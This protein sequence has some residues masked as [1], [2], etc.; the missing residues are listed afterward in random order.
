[1]VQ[2]FCTLCGAHIQTSAGTWAREFR[3][4]WIQGNNFDDVK[5]S[6]VAAGHWH[7]R[8]TS[9]V[10]P[11][12]PNARYDG[13]RTDDDGFPIEDVEISIINLFHPNPPPEWR[14][15]FLFH[16]ACW[17]LLNFEQKVDLGDLFRLCVSTPIGPD[18]LL[19]FGHDYGNIAS[20][21]YEGGIDVL[22]SDLKSP[23]YGSDMLRANPFEIPALRKSIN[24]AAR[25]QQDA[26][27]SILDR[28]TLSADKDVFNYFPPEILERIVMFL[29]SPDV[30]SLRLASRVFATLSLS[31]RFW[32][33]RFTEGHEFDYLPEVFATPPTSWRALYLSLH[34]WASENSGM[35]NR[36]R[37]WPFVKDLHNTL[38]QMKNVECLGNLINTTFEPEAPSSGPQRGSLITAER[39]IFEPG[40]HF[41]G[42]SRVLR[43]RFAEFPQHL[44]IM[45]MSVSF[46]DT[47]DGPF[48]SGLMFVGADGV[49][50]SLGYT[51]K[52]QMEHITLP[53]DQHVKG[54]EVALDVCGFRAIAAIT[55]DGT[56]SSW[57]GD[58]ADS[59]RRRLT[60]VEGISLIVAQF[61]ALKLVS[62]S[63]DRVTK[64][65]QEPRDR[66][67]WHPEIPAPELFL[68]GVRPLD[69]KASS[70]IPIMTVFFGENDGR[71]IRQMTAIDTHI[72][73][74]CHVDRLNFGFMDDSIERC[75]GD[76]EYE[77]EQSDRVPIRFPD[78]GSTMGH[79]EIDGGSGEEIESFEVQFDENII[80]GLKF[81][82]NTN[83]TEL[84]SNGDAPFDVP[85][86]KVTPRGKKIIGMFSQGSEN[87]WGAKTF[88][89]LGF[90]S[91]NEEQE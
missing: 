77:T 39:Y 83:R 30:H 72:H 76:V 55:Q 58:P 60:D 91:T 56:T 25:M 23:N 90:I 24:F 66:L 31:E 67:L 68:D 10:V 61:D 13:R 52:S 88:H 4:I 37:V 75:L 59:P 6:G 18:M 45:L 63:R 53:E 42:G 85:W 47:P 54:F 78:H 9:N 79:F 62:L 15:G 5:L 2:K 8:D 87:R 28:S 27:Q 7:D 46:V 16:D 82:L 3:A 36:S 22:V 11:V 20:M 51:H 64:E 26:F 33:S 21:N 73:D 17:S 14:W 35:G 44:K 41:M 71:Y 69:E 81:N 1:M 65:L 40:T 70:K 38:G 86:T 34:I 84:V 29:P 80:F 48:I 12:D 74:W 50:E 49:F 89:N 57:A 32:A 19:N 43:A